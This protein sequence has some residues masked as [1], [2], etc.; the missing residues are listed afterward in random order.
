MQHILGWISQFLAQV[1]HHDQLGWFRR[2]AECMK[3]G[4]IKSDNSLDAQIF[5]GVQM[6]PAHSKP[7][8]LSY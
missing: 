8:I 1:E 2:C 5:G 4:D 6:K 7:P 3:G